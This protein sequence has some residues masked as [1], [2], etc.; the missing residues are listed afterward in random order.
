MY[1]DAGKLRLATFGNDGKLSVQDVS[2]ERFDHE[3]FGASADGKH[4]F[5]TQVEEGEGRPKYDAQGTV[6]PRSGDPVKTFQIMAAKRYGNVF[7]PPFPLAKLKN[8]ADGIVG[9]SGTKGS[10]AFLYTNFRD[11][12]NSTS[13]LWFTSIP[14]VQS[15]QLAGC[16][17]DNPFVAAGEPRSAFRAA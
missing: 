3:S 6:Q 5:W 17:C 10:L 9:T 16:A 8:R 12:A 2:I 13:D 11:V 15:V 1:T 7:T 4:L 14:W